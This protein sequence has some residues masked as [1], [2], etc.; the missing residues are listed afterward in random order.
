MGTKKV[1]EILVLTWERSD[2]IGDLKGLFPEFQ[3][4][5]GQKGT[6]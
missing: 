6:N 3:R 5:M 1:A 2:K 4:C